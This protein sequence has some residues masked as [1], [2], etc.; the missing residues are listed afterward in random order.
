MDGELRLELRDDIDQISP[1]VA[2]Y[3]N[4][5]A[6]V[7]WHD[8]RDG[9]Y[10][11][12][13]QRMNQGG[14][15]V[16]SQDVRVNTNTGF[17]DEWTKVQVVI[18]SG[19]NAYIV[20]HSEYVE[21]IGNAVYAQRLDRRGNRLWLSDLYV[22]AG[23]NPDIS[24]VSDS[25][26]LVVWNDN[27]YAYNIYAQM[28]DDNGSFLWLDSVHISG[29]SFESQTNPVISPHSSED[30]LIVWTR[31][32]YDSG[33]QKFDVYAQKINSSGMLLWGNEKK[34]NGSSGSLGGTAL[35]VV[36]D[37]A[38]YGVVFWSDDRDPN[39]M[40]DIFAQRLNPFGERFWDEDKKIISDTASI[41]QYDP[42]VVI[43]E[44]NNL[45]VVWRDSFYLYLQKL[46]ENGNTLW[47]NQQRVNVSHYYASSLA[48]TITTNQELLIVWSGGEDSDI[49]VNCLNLDGNHVWAEESR[50]NENDGSVS[51]DNVNIAIDVNGNKFIVWIDNRTGDNRIHVMH[52][53]E[54]GNPL[55]PASIEI[56]T[57][58]LYSQTPA[59]AV[60]DGGRATI[61]WYDSRS[62]SR[63]LYA[64]QLDGNGNRLWLEDSQMDEGVSDNT[65]YHPA[66]SVDRIGNV[67]VVWED[68]RNGNKDIYA[69]KL[70]S[71]GNRLWGDGIRS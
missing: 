5:D 65:P 66:I 49:F 24:F 45:C 32:N 14:D 37:D 64:Q 6:L 10:N 46:D 11:V 48:L 57:T 50:V 67:I 52:L 63:H 56:E 27:N 39:D 44:D 60:D 29:N 4:G 41:S 70:N 22:A 54:N 33:Y 21:G 71:L 8:Y 20:W 69:Q 47:M 28:L 30:S 18:D 53:D 34:V 38:G 3:E 43:C 9:V 7:V 68:Y 25:Q 2:A 23:E 36:L 1:A 12:Y 55:W 15:T 62:G 40:G 61:V 35:S 59:I 17:V 31:T 16:W 58:W 42:E 51:Q 19:D 13:A 26:F